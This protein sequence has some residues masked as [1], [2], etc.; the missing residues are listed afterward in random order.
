MIKKSD[1]FKIGDWVKIHKA[2]CFRYDEKQQRRFYTMTTPGYPNGQIVG[3]TIRRLGKRHW[4]TEDDASW[5]EAN[6]GVFVW[7]IRLGLSNQSID[8]LEEDLE[9]IKPEGNVL[10]WRY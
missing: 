5:F 4:G 1:K 8:V 3:A 2:V 9:L 6:G 7:K 10:P